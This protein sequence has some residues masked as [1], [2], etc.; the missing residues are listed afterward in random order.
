MEKKFKTVTDRIF[1]N[2]DIFDEKLCRANKIKIE[3]LRSHFDAEK[4]WN[5][6]TENIAWVVN[7]GVLKTNELVEW[8]S[9]EDLNKHGIFSK[10]THEVQNGRFI[11]IGKARLIAT[12]HTE[13]ILFDEATAECYDTSFLTCYGNSKGEVTDCMA[14]GMQNSEIIANGS[15]VELFENAKCTN[16]GNSLVIQ[17]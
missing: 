9:E 5:Y 1:S 6:L 11:G 16:K 13:V 4:V 2:K 3:W 17:R 12:L 7:L 10:G 14:T 15:R 8:F